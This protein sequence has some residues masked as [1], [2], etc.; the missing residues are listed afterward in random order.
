MQINIIRIL[1]IFCT[2]F[3]GIIGLLIYCMESYLP[4]FLTRMYCYGK[5]SINI[6]EPIIA[7]TEVPKK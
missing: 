7:K 2:I 4:I 5:Y 3:T 6:Y 1:F